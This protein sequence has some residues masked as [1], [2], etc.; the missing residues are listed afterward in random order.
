MCIRDR[1]STVIDQSRRWVQQLEQFEQ[2][3]KPQGI[4]ATDEQIAA[5][6][7]ATA[8]PEWIAVA[9]TGQRGQFLL[10]QGRGA[11]LQ[12]SD[13]LD[14]TEA[15]AIAQLDLGDTKAKI[16]L[17]LPLTHQWVKELADQNGHWQERVLWDEQT[18]RVKAER[19][20]SL[21]HISEPTRP[22]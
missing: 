19:V 7:V 14:G 8:F 13:P 12:V 22:Y 9:R 15:L 6:L 18:K 16:R 21:I 11:A 5:Q 17:A 2:E 20:L 4:E 1:L 3:Q 10:R